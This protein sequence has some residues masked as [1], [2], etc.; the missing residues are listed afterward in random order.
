MRRGWWLIILKLCVSL[1]LMARGW[2]TYQWDS[3][4]RGLIWNEGW[5]SRFVN[6][7]EFAT[8]SDAAINRGLAIT[9]FVLMIGAIV[10]WLVEIR[11]LRWTYWLL[12]P[13]SL[14][15]IVD[16]FARWIDSSNQIGMALENALQWSCPILLFI[17]VGWKEADRIW[18]V[19]AIIAAVFTFVG[20]GLYAVGF[21]PIP[22]KFQIMTMKL[23]NFDEAGT[24]WF[25]SLFGY[26]DFVAAAF[27]LIKGHL[28]KFALYYMITWGAVTALA[29]VISGPSLDPWLIETIVRSSHWMIPLLLLVSPIST[30]D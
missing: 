11:H 7:A 18:R 10:P 22:L 30:R 1:T 2:L 4:I 14:V 6:W 9:G 20:H 29:R 21:H 3:P 17:A 27:V 16:A 15:L 25:L 28:R 26:L 23:L 24:I 13:L 19:I 5:W 8:H 12:L